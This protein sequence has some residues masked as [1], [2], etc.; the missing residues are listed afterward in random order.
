MAMGRSP[1]G[2]RAPVE[3]SA[4]GSPA[5]RRGRPFG[6]RAACAQR[7]RLARARPHLSRREKWPKTPLYE[8]IMRPRTTRSCAPAR[9]RSRA[10][11]RRDR[12]PLHD[13]DHAPP[14][15]AIALPCTTPITRPRTTRSRSPARRDRAPQ[16]ATPRRRSQAHASPTPP[17]QGRRLSERRRRELRRPLARGSGARLSERQRRELRAPREPQQPIPRPRPEPPLPSRGGRGGLGGGEATS[18]S[19]RGDRPSPAPARRTRSSPRS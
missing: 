10:P 11:A 14:H 5:G 18:S 2:P 17:T 1:L 13:P 15:A 12:A 4:G 8:A 19:S 7:A 6:V 3:G 9:P 16:H